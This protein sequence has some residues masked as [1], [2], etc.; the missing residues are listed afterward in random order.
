[1]RRRLREFRK[2]K[3]AGL[4]HQQYAFQTNGDD[5]LELKDTIED[6]P[7]DYYVPE[8]EEEIT[9]PLE[10]K[11]TIED[12]PDD[13]YDLEEE[14]EK[15]IDPL[16]LKD[17]IEDDYEDDYDFEEEEEI[18]DPLELKDT[19]EDDPEDDYDFEEE[20]E[21]VVD[22]LELKD[23]IEDDYE[24][25]YDFEEEEEILDPL[26]LKDTIEDEEKNYTVSVRVSG[27]VTREFEIS[28]N[29][30]AGELNSLVSEQLE[31]IRTDGIEDPSVVCLD[32]LEI[33]E[34]EG[35]ASE[36]YVVNGW[37][38]VDVMAP[39]PDEAEMKAIRL[40]D[41]GEIVPN[42]DIEELMYD[43]DTIVHEKTHEI[44]REKRNIIEK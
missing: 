37:V 19:I 12:D 3:G 5:P 33:N 9:D 20:E 13:Y 22:P 40:V 8:E 28:D 18:V 17:T 10:L 23:T 25:D 43:G 32:E 27:S 34:E 2:I 1:M 38:D 7:D 6:D 42:P 11:D 39:S 35:Y 36:S 41:T 4:S 29:P 15:V 44:S 16:E 24:D 30:S 14:E 31:S 21:K 26:E